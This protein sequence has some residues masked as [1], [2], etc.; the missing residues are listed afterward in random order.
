[1]VEVDIT[2]DKNLVVDKQINLRQFQTIRLGVSTLR[3]GGI[4]KVANGGD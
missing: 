2:Q 1:M 4:G 3:V